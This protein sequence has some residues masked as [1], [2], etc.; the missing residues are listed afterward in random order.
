M[1]IFVLLKTVSLGMNREDR[2]RL[3][4]DVHCDCIGG[5]RHK[6]ERRNKKQFSPGGQAL[7]QDCSERCWSLHPREILRFQLVNVLSNLI[8]LDPF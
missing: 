5:N 1:S 3:F 6:L 2:A 8:E 7:E 4:L